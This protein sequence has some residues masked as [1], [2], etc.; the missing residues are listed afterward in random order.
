MKRGL[1]AE[2]FN[3]SRNRFTALYKPCSKSTKVSAGQIF[4]CSSSR[5]TT[6]PGCCNS[7]C[8]ICRGCSWSLILTPRLRSSPA[9]KSASNTPNRIVARPECTPAMNQPPQSGRKVYHSLMR[10]STNSYLFNGLTLPGFENSRTGRQPVWFSRTTNGGATWEPAR[11]IF[12]LS[13]LT[14]TIGNQIVVLP[15]G[16]LVDIFDQF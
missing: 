10:R 16:D 9:R 4:C 7:I 14:G 15:N 8:K 6:S 11:N 12:D 2:S 3:A 1:S 5:V 13:E